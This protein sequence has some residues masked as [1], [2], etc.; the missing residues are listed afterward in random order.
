MKKTVVGSA[1]ALAWCVTAPFAQQKPVPTPEAT[2]AHQAFLLTGCLKAGADA[3][4]AFQLTEASSIG[5]APPAGAADVRTVGTSGQKAS[6]TLQPVSGLDAQGMD[7]KA[8]KAHAGRR[9][10]VTV[11]PVEVAPAAASTAS[12]P[13]VQAANPIEPAPERFTVTAIKRVTGTCPR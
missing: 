12:S 7:A 13:A 11:R 6:Y 9:V 3:T 2:P 8:L 1:V 5:Q 10:E 4:A